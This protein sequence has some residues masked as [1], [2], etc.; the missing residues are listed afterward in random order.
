MTPSRLL[1]GYVF[2]STK[3][4]VLWEVKRWLIGFGPEAEILLPPALRDAI[5]DDY[6][7]LV[8]REG[9]E[10]QFNK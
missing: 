2:W 6:Q 9:Q 7:T 1:C 3:V 5:L 8:K 4:A 10:E